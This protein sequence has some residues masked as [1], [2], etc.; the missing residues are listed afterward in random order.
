MTGGTSGIGKAIVR[1]FVSEN[2]NVVF[3]GRDTKRGTSLQSETGALF[4][5]ADS[6]SDH[7]VQHAI[8]AAVDC[9][10]GLDT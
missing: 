9:M 1:R 5:R 4:V 6:S 2:A 8:T 3:T 7:D 10:G